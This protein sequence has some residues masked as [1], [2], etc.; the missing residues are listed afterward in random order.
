MATAENEDS[1]D[2]DEF[3]GRGPGPPDQGPRQA[4]C[5]AGLSARQSAGNSDAC[6][7]SDNHDFKMRS[8]MGRDRGDSVAANIALIFLC[9]LLIVH[10]IGLTTCR[11]AEEFESGLQAAYAGDLDRAIGLW[12]AEIQRNPRCYEAL[13]NRGTA[14]FRNGSVLKGIRDW[15]KARN[16]TPTFAYALASGD[17]INVPRGKQGTLSF[18]KALE[19]EPDFAGDILMAGA[20]YLDL[21]R[22]KLAAE[23]FKK[24][25]ELTKNPILKNEL[26]YWVKGIES[27]PTR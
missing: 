10:T 13:V 14:H 9:A 1:L 12:T 11:S 18:V 8:L 22:K 17:F 6:M 23:L 5:E 25:I 15:Y 16:L 2:G 4:P 7:K 3:R 21:G 20:T 27:R 26:D 19:I 24:S